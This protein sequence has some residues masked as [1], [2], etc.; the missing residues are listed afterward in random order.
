MEENNL[1]PSLI[2][3]SWLE[4][5]SFLNFIPDDQL[6]LHVGFGY[7]I[8]AP[9][10]SDIWRVA[11]I[12]NNSPSDLSNDLIKDYEKLVANVSEEFMISERDKLA[13]IF[14]SVFKTKTGG[15]RNIC[16]DILRIQ[17]DLSNLYNLGLLKE[18][19]TIL[20][21][22]GGYGQMAAGILNAMPGVTYAIVDFPEIL[23]IVYRWISHSHKNIP[24]HS[25]IEK[26]LT[27]LNSLK[28]G[29]NLISNSNWTNFSAKPD[30]IINVNSF[31]EMTE[32]QVLDYIKSPV[33]QK[34]YLYSNN[35][36][37]KFQNGE[38]ASLTKIFSENGFLWPT[39][40]KY[41]Q[42]SSADLKKKIYIYTLN[43]D[44]VVP[45][46]L[47]IK[48]FLGIWGRETPAMI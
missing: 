37:K 42:F 31:C 6:R 13:P 12:Q 30:L 2:W 14:C 8:G 24:I 39:P 23:K 17:A 3:H 40:S 47:D 35:R 36:D 26:S 33:L 15:I 9:I 45:I 34:A 46:K 44:K 38:L 7:Y 1:K 18:S 27:Q 20:E 4:Q 11:R 5:L 22:G 41:E 21:I 43:Q 19:K 16:T 32:S 28:P 10:E 29:L 25:Q 48:D